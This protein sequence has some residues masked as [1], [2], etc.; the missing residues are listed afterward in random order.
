MPMGFAGQALHV[1][2]REPA[3]AAPTTIPEES[4]V[5]DFLASEVLTELQSVRTSPHG[6][7][8]RVF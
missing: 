5:A 1:S 3:Q 7:K 4:A 2:A 8:K 6:A